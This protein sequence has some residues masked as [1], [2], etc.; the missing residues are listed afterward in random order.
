[1]LPLELFGLEEKDSVTYYAFA[2]DNFP[3]RAHHAETDLRFIEIRP[4]RRIYRLPDPDA[5]AGMGTRPPS[6]AGR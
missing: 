5:Q 1:M 4:F 3:G 6:S 2:E